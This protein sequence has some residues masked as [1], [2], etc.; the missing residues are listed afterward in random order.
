MSERYA[1]IVGWGK[2]TPEQVLTNADLER[3]IET[4]DEW[5]VK[6][7]GIRERRIVNPTENTSDMAVAAARDA[8]AMAEVRARDLG[9]IIV[10]T[11]SPDYLTPPVS[12]QIQ[13]ALGARD[14]GAFTLVAGCAGFVYALTTAQQYIANGVCDNVLVIGVELLS[15]FIDWTD[16][17]TCVLFGDGAGAVVLQV[18]NEPAGVL[19]S[20]L[21]SDGSGAE[22]LILPGGGTAMPPT[23][24]TIDQGLHTLKMNGNQVFRFASR[25]IGKALRQVI[26][27]AGLTSDD[28]DLF[29]PHQANL[30]I[31]ESAARY[32]GF[33]EEK[34]FINI[35]RY[36]NTSA[37][38]I[39]IALV[40]AFEQER[41]KVGDT[42]AFVAFGAGLSWAAAVVK[43][44]ERVKPI[45]FLHSRR[46]AP[47]WISAFNP[48]STVVVKPL[49]TALRFMQVGIQLI[50]T[51]FRRILRLS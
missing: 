1:N 44:A 11:S 23:H 31:I 39:P 43:V 14:V 50:T 13:H 16:R 5:I 6:R 45:P 36:G 7:T 24:E 38:S 40:E 19:S 46:K 17:S 2:Y 34:I 30:R 42:L 28:I 41:A 18:S 12:S 49:G 9:L 20:V 25:I 3:M 29:I 33:P 4:T 32:V 27:Q 35:D 47:A 10:A 21:G 48:L 37:A 15:R 22:H 8:L 26:Q 51:W